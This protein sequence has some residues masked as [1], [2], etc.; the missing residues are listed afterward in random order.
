MVKLSAFSLSSDLIKLG[1]GADEINAI[2]NSIINYKY[3]TLVDNQGF[4]PSYK[5]SV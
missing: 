1:Y 2:I 3:I 4:V 5:R